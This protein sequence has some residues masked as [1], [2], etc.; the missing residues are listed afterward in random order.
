MTKTITT[1]AFTVLVIV[2]SSASCTQQP[3]TTPAEQPPAKPPQDPGVTASAAVVGDFDDRVKAYVALHRKLAKETGEID[4]T[5]SPHQI[6][7]REQALGESI[8]AARSQA[9]QGDIFTP[10]V[11]TA[12]KTI[13]KAEYSLRAPA[14]RTDRKEDQ[15]ELADFIP[16]VNQTY[17][18]TSPL[19][20]FPAGLL[21]TLPKLPEEL[22]YRLVQRYLILRDIEANLIIDIIPNATP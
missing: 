14:V 16:T 12:F 8:R 11:E 9:K 20:T 13:I 3:A 1:V 18:P 6:T 4:E 17:P 19:V 5:K 15:D 2:F 21:R 7:Q 22:E 10:Q